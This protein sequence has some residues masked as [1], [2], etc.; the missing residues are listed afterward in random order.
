[1]KLTSFQS[2]ILVVL[3]SIF[4]VSAVIYFY[5]AKDTTLPK[6]TVQEKKA[7]FKALI[8]PAVD[9]VYDELMVQYKDVAASL[10]QVITPMI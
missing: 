10:N 6:M 5:T 3:I 7:R 2:K 9:E 4:L 1:M 8:I